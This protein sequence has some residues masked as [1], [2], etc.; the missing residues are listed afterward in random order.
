MKITTEHLQYLR[1]K[2]PT[3]TRVELLHMEDPYPVPP[4]T[5]GR[6]TEVDDIATIHVQWDNGSSLGVV[7]EDEFCIIKE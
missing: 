4:G 1:S 2:Y 5:K 3:G 7:S 6:V